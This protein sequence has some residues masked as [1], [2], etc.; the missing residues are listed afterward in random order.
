MTENGRQTKAYRM[1][2]R[3]RMID[4][5]TKRTTATMIDKKS[6]KVTEQQTE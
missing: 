5:Q 3:D 6:N 4:R 2:E 1:T